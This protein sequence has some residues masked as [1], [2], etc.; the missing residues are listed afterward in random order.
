MAVTRFR[1]EAEVKERTE[2]LRGQP[3]KER[4]RMLY[5]WVKDGAVDLQ[6]FGALLECA[7]LNAHDE[8]VAA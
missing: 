2:E 4:R 6:V 7:N 5:R 1:F 8:H 3:L